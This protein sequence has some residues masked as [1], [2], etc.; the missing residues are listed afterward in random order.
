MTDDGK[1]KLGER[2]RR[3]RMDAGITQ[4]QLA[5]TLGVSQGVIS[6]VENGV[7]TL[8]VPDLP[9]WAAA[10]GKPIMFFFLDEPLPPEERAAAI[11][12]LLSTKQRERVLQMLE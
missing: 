11:L 8:D 1:K 2:V 9:T 10:L 5:K 4:G 6:N 7:S 3:A 12:D